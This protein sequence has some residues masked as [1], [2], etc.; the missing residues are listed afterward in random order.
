MN[1]RWAKES[2]RTEA[3]HL[4]CVKRESCSREACC[5]NQV[6]HEHLPVKRTASSG[7]IIDDLTNNW[8]ICI[9]CVSCLVHCRLLLCRF[10]LQYQLEGI[11][12]GKDS[13][14]KDPISS[15][16]K[17]ITYHIKWHIFVQHWKVVGQGQEVDNFPSGPFGQEFL[18]QLNQAGWHYLH[19]PGLWKQYLGKPYLGNS[20]MP[21]M[22]LKPFPWN[23][24]DDLSEEGE[25]P[26]RGGLG[27]TFCRAPY[28][29][30]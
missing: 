11:E 9:F 7:Q 22:L 23:S 15:T 1:I 24:A 26:W 4:H 13:K 17:K 30:A 8:A 19:S 2:C 20:E 5:Y 18:A 27:I 10:C 21:L 6:W 25:R 16:R 3:S 28:L 14:V 29:V 12:E